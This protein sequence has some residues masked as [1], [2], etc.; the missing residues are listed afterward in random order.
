MRQ[1]V[2]TVGMFFLLAAVSGGVSLGLERLATVSLP[3]SAPESS[4]DDFIPPPAARFAY[5]IRKVKP[6][7]VAPIPRR[8]PIVSSPLRVAGSGQDCSQVV[9]PRAKDYADSVPSIAACIRERY[10]AA[11]KKAAA[12]TAVPEEWILAV[13]IQESEGNHAAVSANNCCF[14]LMQLKSSTAA[15]F[16]VREEQL[17][18]P[19]QNILGG[20][21]ALAKYMRGSSFPFALLQYRF[22]ETG[23]SREA[24]NTPALKHP[25]VVG[26]LQILQQI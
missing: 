7:E 20:A 14:G 15:Q 21:R 9:A 1:F 4:A 22:G 19:T 23:A 10:G 11:I 5:T 24:A 13:M 16:G 8:A 25:Y 6:R 3:S 12:E 26:V 17:L 18:D 2:H